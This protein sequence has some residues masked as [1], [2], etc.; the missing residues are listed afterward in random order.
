MSAQDD[1]E[2]EYLDDE[3]QEPEEAIVESTASLP[4]LDDE[5][6]DAMPLRIL[7]EAGGVTVVSLSG[8][9]G[10]AGRS[11]RSGRSGKS[12]RRLKKG[13]HS[14]GGNGTAGTNGKPG[15]RGRNA[16]NATLA[17]RFVADSVVIAGHGIQ[18]Q[19]TGTVVINASGGDGGP[20]GDGGSGGGSGFGSPMGRSGADGAGGAGGDGGDGGNVT[21]TTGDAH[22]LAVIDDIHVSGGS[23][24]S[25]GSGDPSGPDGTSGQDGSYCYQVRNAK[26]G[27]V[28]EDEDF[29]V[30]PTDLTLGVSDGSRLGGNFTR[31][32]KF[33][34]NGAT[35]ENPT[36]I[37]IL[38]P[39]MLAFSSESPIEIAAPISGCEIVDL[40]ALETTEVPCSVEAQIRRDGDIGWFEVRTAVVSRRG[41][42]NLHLNRGKA[43]GTM[44]L[45]VNHRLVEPEIELAPGVQVEALRSFIADLNVAPPD[46][47]TA[48]FTAAALREIA[49][50][51]RIGIER[52]ATLS[53][54]LE[55]K[56]L[57]PAKL[58]AEVEG[59][60]VGRQTVAFPAA[61]HFFRSLPLDSRT[62]A[63]DAAYF[64]ACEDR[65]LDAEEKAV[66]RRM[67]G[68]ME[69][70][71]TWLLE[72]MPRVLQE[73]ASRADATRTNWLPAAGLPLFAGFWFLAAAW[74]AP[75]FAD[76]AAY[77]ASHYNT[78]FHAALCLL[79]LAIVLQPYRLICFRAACRA[80]GSQN[81]K[82]VAVEKQKATMIGSAD[83]LRC[84]D[85]GARGNRTEGDANEVASADCG[86]ATGS[87]V[88][89]V[90]VSL[91]VGVVAVVTARLVGHTPRMHG[92]IPAAA[93]TAVVALYSL[94]VLRTARRV[95]FGL[96]ILGF[97]GGAG[98]LGFTAWSAKKELDAASVPP[99]PPTVTTAPA[100]PAPPPPQYKKVANTHGEGVFLR[101]SPDPNDKLRGVDEGTRLEVT[102]V[103]KS[104]K[105]TDWTEVRIPEGTAWVPTKFVVD[106]PAGA[107]PSSGTPG[108]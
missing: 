81:L 14:A 48:V 103:T 24:G 54:M 99:P 65:M 25:G 22:L 21:I 52:Q 66:L 108:K 18:E 34:I 31:G 11:G 64:I 91:G 33:Q 71:E 57:E 74:V 76:A 40:S 68:K 62:K 5:E 3:V 19:I 106:A 93:G 8:G 100:P 44:R 1:D 39:Y 75:G 43:D 36:N 7:Q 46:R 79:V 73:G 60:D 92:L 15:G 41:E 28:E 35:V 77:A 55:G 80:C 30:E 17:L 26:T 104:Q 56:L 83:L 2:D 69:I 49:R 102:G 51:R 90:L 87:N 6:H 13:G 94:A 32:S 12:G 23:A 4:E 50:G 86:V 45:A 105:G 29:G 38:A 47:Q 101:R 10:R 88:V 82:E 61:L 63:L 96:L 84:V 20:G 85:C 107:T 98:G 67:A 89:P 58:W 97:L 27:E 42:V 9:D 16:R 37:S 95:G 72:H 59:V 53:R 70:A 78:A